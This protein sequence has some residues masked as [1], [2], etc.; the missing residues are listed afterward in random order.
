MSG[1]GIV[2]NGWPADI[3]GDPMQDKGGVAESEL[4]SVNI[5]S[6]AQSLTALMADR[7]QAPIGLTTVIDEAQDRQVFV[8][9]VGLPEPVAT[10]RETPLSHSF[11]RIVKAT[12]APLIV[13]DAREDDRLRDNPVIDEM[14][15][16]AYLGYPL[17]SAKGEPLGS[18]CVLDTE[19]RAWTEAERDQLRSFAEAINTQI[20]LGAALVTA[21]EAR[22]KAEAANRAL[23]EANLRFQ[24]LAD[25]VPGAIF[26]YVESAEGQSEIEFMS[27]G[28]LDLWETSATEV[29]TDATILWKMVLPEDLPAMV[30]SVQRSA[31]ALTP[32]RHRWR[33]R[34]A[35]GKIKWVDSYG[36]PRRR[37]DGSIVW[38]SLNIDVTTA[39]LAE[40]KAAE[41]L[42]LLFEAGKQE[43]IGRLAGGIAH[44]FNNLLMVVRGNAEALTEPK[45]NVDR[46]AL[47]R[48]IIKA[49]DLGADLTKRLVSFARKAD[50]HP[51]R[52]DVNGNVQNLREMLRRVLPENISFKVALA[53]DLPPIFVDEGFLESALLNLV[54]NARDAMPSGGALTM[55]TALVQIT[56]EFLLGRGE[57]GQPGPY[58]M[59]AVTDT[60]EGMAPDVLGRIFD[61]FFT[62]KAP[63]KGTGLGLPMVEGFVRQSGG[64]IRVYSE[65]GHGSSFRIYLP[66]GEGVIDEAAHL[67][68]TGEGEAGPATVL[69]VEDQGE[70][71]AILRSILAGSGYTVI[72]ADSGDAG[73]ETFSHHADVIDIVVSD[74]VMPGRLQGPEMVRKIR[75]LRSD[76]PVIYVSGYPHEANVHGN[77]IRKADMTLTKPVSR[78]ALRAAVSRALRRTGSL[79]RI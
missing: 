20:S 43:T 76:T 40:Q 45:M 48:S 72:E 46:V 14:G 18:V 54:F 1:T 5:Q 67:P 33:L 42:R 30:A 23:V 69:L 24:D 19:P 60:G 12:D 21:E 32:W 10:L 4:P 79:T 28:C 59:M 53:D 58:V 49:A 6:S 3:Y 11:C 68:D 65:P 75:E 7:L 9:A 29:G 38:N 63:T 62:T 57:T 64:M 2:L 22:R 61:P 77:G 70:V 17:R 35:S 55:E 34:T 37:D 26:R 41:T 52:V 36:K 50:L 16:I 47:G 25:N 51:A 31:K 66:V 13:T 78:D 27:P 73:L 39:V 44:D 71:R 8:A 56:E 15:V 74:V